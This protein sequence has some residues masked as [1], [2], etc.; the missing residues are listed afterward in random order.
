M[1]SAAR[2]PC[3]KSSRPKARE[4]TPPPLRSTIAQPSW[5]WFLS[6]SRQ[7]FRP[8]PS[9]LLESLPNSRVY[10]EWFQESSRIFQ[11]CV[12]P[13]ECQLRRQVPFKRRYLLHDLG[14]FHWTPCPPQLPF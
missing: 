12:F 9:P 5:F 2:S 3:D 8:Q 6:Q 7:R 1:G 10:A 14:G 11:P 4:N 13:E